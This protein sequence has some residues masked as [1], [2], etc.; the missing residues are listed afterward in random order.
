V[1]ATERHLPAD[2]PAANMATR[3]RLR[4][5][6]AILAS[7]LLRLAEQPN[8]TATA[9]SN[10]ALDPDVCPADSSGNSLGFDAE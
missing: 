7:G 2:V 9:D 1:S 6:A 10:D 3:N 5:V 4:E 8:R